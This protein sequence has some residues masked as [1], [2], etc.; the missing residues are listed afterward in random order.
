MRGPVFA[1]RAAGV[2]VLVIGIGLIA[3]ALL[4]DILDIGGGRGFGY[5]QLIV[6]IAGMVAVLFA[7]AILRQ[8]RH[9]DEA[10]TE[11]TPDAD[12]ENDT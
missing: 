11:Y 12:S 9:H 2:T 6:L 1:S 10:D 7:G 3:L 5:Q 8:P 4:A